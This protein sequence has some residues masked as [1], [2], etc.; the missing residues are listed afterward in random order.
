[1]YEPVW[2][3][4][5]SEPFVVLSDKWWTDYLPVRLWHSYVVLPSSHRR[6]LG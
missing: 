6:L 3:M 4:S 2:C 5:L 1:V